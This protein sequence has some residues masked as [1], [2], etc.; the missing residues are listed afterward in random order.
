[1]GGSGEPVPGGHAPGVGPD[2]CG[3]VRKARN[4]FR[5]D[6]V[7]GQGPGGPACGQSWGA[8]VSRRRCGWL[9]V[10]DARAGFPGYC[11]V[12]VRALRLVP[13]GRCHP[14]R[15]GG[16]L[17]PAARPSGIGRAVVLGF[18][19]G[20]GS[21]L[22]FGLRHPDRVIGLILANCRLGGGVTVSTAFAQPVPRPRWRGAEGDQRV[23]GVG[24]A[25]VCVKG[26]AVSQGRAGRLVGGPVAAGGA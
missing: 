21:A 26:G 11:A 14:G 3:P 7:H 19:A 9:V 8:G 23:R 10:A 20:S 25:G 6:R 4:R 24:R 15:A 16:R 2:Q 17:R 22:E 1:L 12:S 18:S 13:A 5:R